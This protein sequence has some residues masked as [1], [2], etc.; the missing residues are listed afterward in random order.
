M[1]EFIGLNVH[2]VQFKPDLYKP[3]CRRLR[4]YHPIAWDLQ[5]DPAHPSAFPLAANGVDWGG[6]YGSWLRVG[7]DIDACL[8]FDDVPPTLWKDP[9]HDAQ[10][11]GEAFARFFGP[12]GKKLVSSIEVG[13]EPSK[14]NE[15]QYRA[16][17]QGMAAGIRKGDPKLM[18]ATCAVLIGKPDEWSKPMSAVAGLESLYDVLNVHSYAFKDGWPTWHR[19]FPEDASIPYLKQVEAVIR[20]R[21]EHAAGKRVWLTEFGYDS[22]SKP[23]APDGP[24]AKWVGMTDAEQARYIV[25]SYLLFSAM[26]LNRAYLYFFNDKDEAQL[27]G[28]S[29][30]TRNFAPKPSFYAVAHLDKSL[31]EY[32]FSR[33]LVRRDGDLYCFEY[34]HADRPQERVMVA[35]VPTGDTKAKLK[36]LPLAAGSVK[37]YRAERMPQ[38]RGGPATVTW[39]AVEDHVEIEVGG[40]PVFLWMH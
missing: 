21:D 8:I 9:Q 16:I 19:S 31:G 11:Y 29:G 39:K 23:P 4:D 22:A 38:D 37:P 26:D 33:A 3:I 5:P 36:N 35:W 18:I 30:I 28:A 27:H 40:E 15:S 2:T 1:H 34:V 12:S 24:W 14:Y 10:V 25:R 20:W 17:F 32:R 13:N 7:Y 6:L